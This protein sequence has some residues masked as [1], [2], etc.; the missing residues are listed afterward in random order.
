M[1]E[2][3]HIGKVVHFF[4]KISVAVVDLDSDLNIGD[5]VHFDGAHTNFEQEVDSMQVENEAVEEVS[6]GGEVAIKVKER[7]RTG[8]TL[9][10]HKS[11]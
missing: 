4:G 9:H 11:E 5:T 7:V 2:G 10:M 1:A 6:A 8:D 3:K